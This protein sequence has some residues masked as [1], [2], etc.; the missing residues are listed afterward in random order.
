[1][2]LIKNSKNTIHNLILKTKIQNF[3]QIDLNINED[4]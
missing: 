2:K 4:L 3:L 1:M